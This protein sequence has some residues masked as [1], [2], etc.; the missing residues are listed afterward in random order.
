M[1]RVLA[2]LGITIREFTH[3]VAFGFDAIEADARTLTETSETS[4]EASRVGTRMVDRLKLMRSY[5]DYL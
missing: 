2:A 3:E 5:V 4:T 1:M